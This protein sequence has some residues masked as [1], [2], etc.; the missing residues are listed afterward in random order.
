[1]P[2][3]ALIKGEMVEKIAEATTL[4]NGTSGLPEE[5]ST[6]RYANGPFRTIDGLWCAAYRE[7][8]MVA[9]RAPAY[10]HVD[11]FAVALNVSER[12]GK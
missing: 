1:M 2:Y 12:K 4:F 8:P 11:A 7:P 9:V 6:A 5:A 3:N 10:N